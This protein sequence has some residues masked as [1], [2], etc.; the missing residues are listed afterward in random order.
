MSGVAIYMEGGGNTASTKAMLRQ[1]MDAFLTELK[2]L[3]REK[4]WNWKLVCCGGRNQ[5]FNSFL[6]ARRDSEATIVVLLVDAEGPVRIA[7]CAHL[8]AR[9]GWDLRGV[10]DDDVHLMAQTMEAWIV[11]DQGTLQAYYG[12]HF[13]GNVLPNANNLEIVAKDRVASALDQATRR[14]LPKGRYRKIRH[15]SDL[16]KLIDPQ[17]VRQRCPNCKRLFVAVGQAIEEA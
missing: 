5:A 6:N 1:G 10:P 16:L 7:P 3:A 11:A 8:A 15:A 12:Q 4:A 9:D 17:L 14:A 13:G 2:N